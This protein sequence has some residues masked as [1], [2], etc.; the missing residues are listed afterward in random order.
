MPPV[1]PR[2]NCVLSI[3]RHSLNELVVETLK[4]RP[5]VVAANRTKAAGASHI[6]YIHR[7]FCLN[8]V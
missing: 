6:F 1:H 5:V 7:H 4:A 2:K 8:K 3:H